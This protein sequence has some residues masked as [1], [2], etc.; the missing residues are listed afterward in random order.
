MAEMKLGNGSEYQL[1]RFLGHHQNEL[2]G[3]RLRNT[4]INPDLFYVC[5]QIDLSYVK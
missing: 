4:N 5:R 2:E 3:L 1:L